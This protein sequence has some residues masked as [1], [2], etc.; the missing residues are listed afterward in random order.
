MKTSNSS[1]QQCGER[2]VDLGDDMA[3]DET[4]ATAIEYSLI[5]GLISFAILLTLT[6][7]GRVIDENVFTVL[8]TAFQAM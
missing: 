6:A 5:V 8:A 4:G 7:I 1:I 2:L 3:C